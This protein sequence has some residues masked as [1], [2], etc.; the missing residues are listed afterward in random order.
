MKAEGYLK[1]HSCRET[2]GGGLLLF[3]L[4]RID[5]ATSW[6]TK[7]RGKL[8]TVVDFRISSLVYRFPHCGSEAD[9]PW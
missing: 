1:G 7:F 6:K 8:K 5:K 2:G 3:A 4:P 9:A